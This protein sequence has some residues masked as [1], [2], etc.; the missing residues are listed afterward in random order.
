MGNDGRVG[1]LFI[2]IPLLTLVPAAGALAFTEPGVPIGLGSGGILMI[3]NLLATRNTARQ[4]TMG[5]F[6]GQM[7]AVFIQFGKLG[8]T[9]LAIYFLLR[10]ELAA[11]AALL[12]GLLS[13]PASLV[14]DILIFPVNKGGA[15]KT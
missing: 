4:I 6:P 14:F 9:G 12:A 11:P 1:R 2:W 8:L 10:R 15:K 13:L 5:T 3:L 7:V